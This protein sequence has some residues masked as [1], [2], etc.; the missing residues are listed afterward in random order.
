MT[1]TCI[2]CCAPDN[3]LAKFNLVGGLVRFF[4][5]LEFVGGK[6][7][8]VSCILRRPFQILKTLNFTPWTWN[9]EFFKF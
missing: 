5:S 1:M 4:G 2:K 8:K 9:W 6:T 3:Y 7:P